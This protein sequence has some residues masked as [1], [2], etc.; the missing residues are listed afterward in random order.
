MSPDSIERGRRWNTV[1]KTNLPPRK[2]VQAQARQRGA[3]DSGVLKTFAEQI[4]PA[5]KGEPRYPPE[6]YKA[7][8]DAIQSCQLKGADPKPAAARASQAID[9]FL[10]SYSGAPIV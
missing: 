1:V 9:S 10:Q 8:S 5:G 7:I 2:S 4:A 6:V 3:F